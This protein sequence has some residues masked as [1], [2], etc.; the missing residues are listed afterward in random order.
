MILSNFLKWTFN[1]SLIWSW[2]NM[3]YN[4]CLFI[5]PCIYDHMYTFEHVCCLCVWRNHIPAAGMPRPLLRMWGIPWVLQGWVHFIF[6]LWFS[7]LSQN[8]GVAVIIYEQIFFYSHSFLLIWI[9]FPILCELRRV[10]P[11]YTFLCM[12]KHLLDLVQQ[13]ICILIWKCL[14]F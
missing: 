12:C 10:F 11:I 2:V 3:H 9:D 13:K 1:P 7:F 14:F 8:M 5:C 4:S 6:F